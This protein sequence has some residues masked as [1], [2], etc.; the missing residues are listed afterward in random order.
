MIEFDQTPKKTATIKV[1][2]LGGGGGNAVQNMIKCGLEGVEF[3]AANTDL[4][5]L[6]RSPAD[7]KIQLGQHLTRGLGAG[8]DPSIGKNAALEDSATI[9]EALCGSDMVFIT[10]GMGGGTGTGAAP[11]VAE[12][13]REEGA[14]TV[15]VVTKPFSFEGRQRMRQADEGLA[16]LTAAVDTLITI[17][18]DRL[19]AVAPPDTPAIKAFQLADEVCL[20]AVQ[21]ISD[22]ITVAGYVNVDF[23]DVR[24]IMS[25]TG[26]ALMGAGRASG[27]NRAE[28]AAQ[29]AISS[30]LLEDCTIDGARGILINITGGLDLGLAEINLASCLIQEAAHPDANIIFGTVVDESMHDEIKVTVIATGFGSM[31]YAMSE[32]AEDAYAAGIGRRSARRE[33]GSFRRES[34]TFP[35]EEVTEVEAPAQVAAN[36]TTGQ[37]HAIDEGS[38][39]ASRRVATYVPAGSGSVDAVDEEIEEPTFLRKLRKVRNN[40]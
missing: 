13:A 3:I 19:L 36:R 4:Q 6:E 2:G 33:S 35:I 24:T 31:D 23:A 30:P 28:D 8:A 27:A 39:R 14:L 22:L 9:S 5:A 20:N 12:L 1:I 7:I 40:W 15:A 11:V 38:V 16:A 10:A 29:M 32:Y 18:N 37:M 26:R 25:Q 34:G 17:P 21:G